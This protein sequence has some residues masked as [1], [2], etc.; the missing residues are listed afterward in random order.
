MTERDDI[1]ETLDQLYGGRAVKGNITAHLAAADRLAS[2]IYHALKRGDLRLT[3]ATAG[4]VEVQMLD[5]ICV[6]RCKI[7]ATCYGTR[8]GHRVITPGEKMFFAKKTAKRDAINLCE[9][10]GQREW[11]KRHGRKA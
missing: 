4:T 2:Q 5:F 11:E 8:C 7:G 6:P 10:C 1:L 9:T 3:I